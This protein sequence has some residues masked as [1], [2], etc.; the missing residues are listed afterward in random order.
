MGPRS[1]L[2][3]VAVVLFLLAAFNVDLG[4]LELIPLGLAAFAGSFLVGDRAIN[5]R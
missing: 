3:I 2:L 1:I 4:E 5:R